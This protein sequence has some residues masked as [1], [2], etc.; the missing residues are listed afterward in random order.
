MA[1]SRHPEPSPVLHRLADAIRLATD[2]SLDALAD[3]HH[4]DNRSG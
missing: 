3:V 4:A 1:L 2:V